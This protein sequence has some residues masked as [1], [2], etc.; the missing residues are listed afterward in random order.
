MR[1]SYLVLPSALDISENNSG[2][3][4]AAVIVHLFYDDKLEHSFSFVRNIPREIDT[5]IVSAN[6]VLEN[7]ACEIIERDGLTNVKVLPKPNRGRDFSALFVT[8]KEILSKYEYVCFVHDKKSHKGDRQQLGELW[9]ECLFKCTLGSEKYIRNIVRKFE[10][11]KDLGLLSVPVPPDEYLL[12]LD[13]ELWTINY[14]ITADFLSSLGLK[15]IPEYKESPLYVGSAFW[16]RTA[17]IK[18]LIDLDLKYEDF[19]K[20]PMSIDGTF[21]HVLER[22]FG[23]VADD[24]GYSCSYVTPLEYSEYILTKKTEQLTKAMSVLRVNEMIS[25]SNNMVDL[26]A[27]YKNS[28]RIKKVPDLLEYCHKFQRIFIFTDVTVQFWKNEI[29]ED[30]QGD[31][32]V[33]GDVFSGEVPDKAILKKRNNGFVICASHEK[34]DWFVQMLSE[35]GRKAFII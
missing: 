1:V 17:A 22:S 21:A 28:E 14:S 15:H 8:S 12:G 32:I 10:E 4:K 25:F 19:P 27:S 5:Y 29:V 18:K 7:K 3:K 16:F 6:P 11:N 30:L 31:G 9:E 2:L 13:G 24:A 23:F 33:I 34:K 35:Y 26:E 20:E